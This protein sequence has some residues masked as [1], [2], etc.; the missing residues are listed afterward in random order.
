MYA[1][2]PTTA[3]RKESP[4]VP[5]EENNPD[6]SDSSEGDGS[7]EGDGSDEEGS[8]YKEVGPDNGDV[9]DEGEEGPEEDEPNNKEG[10]EEPSPPLPPQTSLPHIEVAPPQTTPPPTSSSPKDKTQQPDEDTSDESEGYKFVESSVS[11]AGNPG[12][13]NN[14][15]E[16]PETSA[17]LLVVQLSAAFPPLLADPRQILSRQQVETE[18]RGLRKEHG[19]S[20]KSEEDQEEPSPSPTLH[21]DI[22]PGRI[23]EGENDLP[24]EGDMVDVPSL[25]LVTVP[26]QLSST[27]QQ[28]SPAK[29]TPDTQ[30]TKETPAPTLPRLS[31]SPPSPR[32][33]EGTCQ[34]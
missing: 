16:E 12:G 5:G 1:T 10:L 2:I 34:D 7:N 8:L 23:S 31:S 6:E 27:S 19:L 32:S 22:A 9:S 21:T 13:R 20:E 11:E 4:E 14:M 18:A 15:D 24:D 26:P 33:S 30:I 17:L 28:V 3:E 25:A 29:S